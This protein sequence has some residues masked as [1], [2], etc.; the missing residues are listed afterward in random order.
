MKN[1]ACLFILCFI[2]FFAKHSVAQVGVNTLTPDASAILDL[3]S[4]DK[5]MLVPRMTSIERGLINSPANGLL[6]F[7]TV[8]ES[9]WY[10]NTLTWVEMV[11]AN[12][13]AKADTDDQ[14]LSLSGT[15]LSIDNGNSVSLSSIDTDTDNQAIDVL[16][17]NGST[18]EVSLDSDGEATKTLDL[19]SLNSV[20]NVLEDGDSDTKIQL[21]EGVDEDVIRFDVAGSE[22]LTIKKNSAGEPL[23]TLPENNFNTFFGFE[24]GAVN[25]P[26]GGS[27]GRLNSFFGHSAGKSNTSGK[28]NTFSGTYAGESNTSGKENVF[29]GVSAGITNT[30]GNGNTFIG[31]YVGEANS[32]GSNNTAIG[33]YAGATNEAGTGNTYVGS[34][35]GST[36][37]T[38]N[39]NTYLGIN[40]GTSMEGGNNNLILGA[41]AGYSIENANNNTLL[42]YQTGYNNVIGNQNVLL[43]YQSGYNELGSNKLYIENSNSSSPLIYGEFDNDLLRIN[44]ELNINNAFSFPTTDGIS[45]QVLETDGAGNLIWVNS[46]TAAGAQTSIEDADGDTKIQVEEGA[47]EDIIRFDQGGVEYFKMA[48]GRLGIYNTGKSVIIGE[49]AGLNDDLTNNYN[50]FIGY[51]SGKNA[52]GGQRNTGLGTETLSNL[53]NGSWNVGV[54]S[55]SLNDVTTGQDNIAIGSPALPKLTTGQWNT[56][57]GTG[58]LNALVTGNSN[59]AMGFWAGYNNTGGSNVFVGKFAGR[60]TLGS[61]NVFI[62]NGAGENETGSNRLY[63]SN[64]GTSEPL[65]Y[66]EFDNN[67]LTVNGLLTA[68]GN[69]ICNNLQ[70]SGEYWLPYERGEDNEVLV[71]DGSTGLS[72]WQDISTIEDQRLTLS[73]NTLSISSGNSV[74]LSSFDQDL[75]LSGTNLGITNGTSVDLNDAFSGSFIDVRSTDNAE[76]GGQ[77]VSFDIMGTAEANNARIHNNL[78]VSNGGAVIIADGATLKVGSGSALND[79]IKVTVN[80]NVGSIS[81]NSSKV[82]TFTVSGATTSGVVYVSVNGQLQSQIV[83]AQAWVSATNVVSVRFR[84]TDGGSEN[85]D[86]NGMDYRFVVIQ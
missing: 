28:S 39:N 20:Q 67:E 26:G 77:N 85:P 2:V 45:G 59:V 81:G 71:S 66:G 76:A 61:S 65:I 3:K 15:T 79:I 17:L 29:M 75:I 48:A 83:I 30:T 4:S 27:N 54:G 60:F 7:D 6:V 8:T 44:G 16:N 34:N 69:V 56:A 86:G 5:G 42:G 35:A 73:G 68:T 64:S 36:N 82:E 32:T 18:L 12:D 41:E 58:A 40:T 49:E 50:T 37:E 19:S 74:S 84:N 31:S 25:T 62:G 57:L 22:V 10:W 13:L 11:N 55:F 63:I 21:E 38:G 43:G 14:A 53:T 24:A 72:Y 33:I 23:F 47:D 80:K 70:V 52:I 46:G 51:Q 78:N 9:F 1:I